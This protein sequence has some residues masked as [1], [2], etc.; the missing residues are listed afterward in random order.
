MSELRTWLAELPPG[1]CV[2][3]LARSWLGRL[4]V[5]VDG[6]PEIFPVNHVIDPVDGSV[7]FPTRDGTKLHAALAAPLVAFEVD[8][9]DPDDGSGWSVLLV[10]RAEVETDLDVVA[11][12][13]GRRGVPWAIHDESIWLRIR[14]A[15]ITGR[16]ISLV[17]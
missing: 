7:L 11:W 1:T 17:V 4:A 15:R 16:R 10:G 13:T 2:A 14:P 6:H 12:A 5:D 9:V 8:G 3:L